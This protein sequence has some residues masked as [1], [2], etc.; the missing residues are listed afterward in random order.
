[1]GYE[2]GYISGL[3]IG[4]KGPPN[5]EFITKLIVALSLDQEEQALLRQAVQESQRRYLLPGDAPVEVFQMMHELWQEMDELHPAQIQMIRDV[6]HLRNRISMPC[7]T[8][9]SG[10]V[11]G[12]QKQEAQM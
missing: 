10:R 12:T 5:D 11:L 4:R 6:L 2:Q 7:R 1:M 9:V 3:E 8:A